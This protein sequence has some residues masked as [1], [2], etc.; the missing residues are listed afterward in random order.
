M[1]TYW[2]MF[3]AAATAAVGNRVQPSFGGHLQP[4]SRI[5]LAWLFAAVALV[6]V[7]GLRYEVGGD[8]LAYLGYVLRVRGLS[9]GEAQ[10]L[11]DPGYQLFNWLSFQLGLGIYGVN[12]ASAA[13][14]VSGLVVFC[15][16]QPRP[17]LALVVSIP[18][19]VLVLGM[20][21][22]RQG[23]ALG[24]CMIGLVALGNRSTL[25]FVLWTLLAATFHKSAVLLIPIAVLASTRNRVWTAVWVGV[26]A[27]AAYL[28]L[29]ADEVD[30]L[31]TNYVLAEYQSQGALIRLLMNAVPAMLFLVWRRRFRFSQEEY[32]L[33]YWISALSLLMLVVLAV[34]PS[35]TAVDRV[36]LYFLPLQLVIFSRLPEALGGWGKNNQALVMLVIFYYGLVQFV[37]LNYSTHAFAWL[38][39]KFAPFQ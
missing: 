24:L 2:F 3:F 11:G 26:A 4:S 17:A 13:C 5:L 34:S 19:M 28:V 39:Y 16:A 33:W 23:V 32:K 18:Y 8:W 35:S 31:Y 1:L 12:L 37:W 27:F 15:R 10:A 36:A 29:L 7:I 25:K 22:S 6:L 9:L 38:P 21:Y 14:F 30:A 20:G